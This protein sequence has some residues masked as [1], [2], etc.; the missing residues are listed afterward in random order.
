MAPLT[1]ARTES[2]DGMRVGAHFIQCRLV[3]LSCIVAVVL[4]QESASEVI[5]EFRWAT[6]HSSRLE[7]EQ[8]MAGATQNMYNSGIHYLKI[9]YI[10]RGFRGC[11][12]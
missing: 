10:K 12:S 5:P 4:G 6:R 7:E 9:F 11:L 8:R 2:R 3:L 1:K